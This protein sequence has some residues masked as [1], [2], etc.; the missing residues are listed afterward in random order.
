MR[1]ILSVVSLVAFLVTAI[2]AITAAQT[3]SVNVKAQVE[4]LL[5]LQ[6]QLQDLQ[7]QAKAI[8]AQR[9]GVISELATT[10]RSGSQGSQV[11]TLQALLAADSEIYPEGLITGYYGAATTRAV[12]RF[13]TKHKLSPV[14]I[15]G[16]LTRAK[17]NEK[18]KE[19]PIVF[20]VSQTTAVG[21][22]AAVAVTSTPGRPCAIVPPGHLIAPGW[23]R[24]HGGV[25]PI[26]P[27]CQTLPPGIAKKLGIVPPVSTST[28]PDVT[29]PAIFSIAVG[30]STSTAT[31]TWTTNEPA[32]SQVFYDLTSA[33]G[34]STILDAALLVSHTQTL[35]GL[36]PG[37]AYHYQ[38]KSRDG[39]GNVASSSDQ[40]F[41]TIAVDATP[42]AISSIGTSA[43]STTATISWTTNESATSK[44]YYGTTNPIDIA[45]TS[46]LQVSITTLATSH[47]LGLTGLNASTT[48]F[49]V[50]ESADASANV[51]TST[52][53]SFTTN[54]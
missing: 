21:G 13:Q 30:T 46:T 11:Q 44:V 37:T 22:S 50:I 14:G 35:T 3:A 9:Q 33:Y 48:Y 47:A 10:L 7:A 27:L 24:K 52:Q 43:A 23:L 32:D 28:P 26:V 17:L 8:Q 19:T 36:T 54:P 15:V 20:E 4:L 41:T 40:T 34:S 45:S 39:A 1:K 31:V 29:P 25:S 2:P 12:I 5:K 42:P 53:Q 51:S 16:P 49:F 38:V 6:K 18:L